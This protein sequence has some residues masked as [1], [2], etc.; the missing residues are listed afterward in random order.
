[1]SSR[2]LYSG[3]AHCVYPVYL[4]LYLSMRMYTEGVSQRPQLDY[5]LDI[6][7]SDP[8]PAV[9]HLVLSSLIRNHDAISCHNSNLN[10][11]ALV[12]RLWK[13]MMYV[14]SS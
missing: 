6:A 10:T 14:R 1:M 12:N 11:V 9:R 8:V 7:E 13:L 2:H 4:L 3:C 5:L